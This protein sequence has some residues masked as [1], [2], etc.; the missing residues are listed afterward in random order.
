MTVKSLVERT[1]LRSGVP[2]ASLRRLRHGALVLAYHGVRPDGAIAA[3]E[4]SL[5]VSR[6]RFARQ[7]DLLAETH[8]V[9]PLADLL[10]AP[11]GGRRPRAAVTFDD[12]YLGALRCGVPELV[13][14]RMPATVFVAP[15]ILGVTATWWDALAE[16][17]GGVTPDAVRDEAL[18]RWVGNAERVVARWPE[19]FG[20][21]SLLP[22]WARPATE[23]ELVE[24]A[25]SPGIS[26]APHSWSHPN[27][28]RLDP[29][30]LDRELRRP[31]AWLEERFARTLP[32]I[33]YPY[34]RVSP[35]VERAAQL[36]GYQWGL[37]V[38]GGWLRPRTIELPFAVPRLNIPAA[39]SDDGFRL[40]ARG[41]LC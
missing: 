23:R 18:E 37:R 41:L 30:T 5:H 19:E 28:A 36:A 31:L 1:L 25:S 14:R 40:R 13:A 22:D 7:L 8:E 24:M 27:L 20:R 4:R 21:G 11:Q 10:A 34:G 2:A 35:A 9:V 15:G 17:H 26:V 33:A 6:A 29:D 3:G 39:L 16:A 38:D 12:A 32:I